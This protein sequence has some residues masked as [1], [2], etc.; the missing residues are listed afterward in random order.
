MGGEAEAWIRSI[1]RRTVLAE[2]RGAVGREWGRMLLEGVQR[3]QSTSSRAPPPLPAPLPAAG[4]VRGALRALRRVGDAA[5][6]AGRGGCVPQQ[7][8][9]PRARGFPPTAAAG[10]GAPL[11]AGGVESGASHCMR[12]CPCIVGRPMGARMAGCR[13]QADTGMRL[14]ARSA[15]KTVMLLSGPAS[16]LKTFTSD[17]RMRSTFRQGTPRGV[18]AD[19]QTTLGCMFVLRVSTL[20]SIGC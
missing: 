4:G 5:G 17:L 3:E 19:R 10:R 9:R 14:S 13:T 1:E 8:V 15:A 6:A 12:L 11:R 7:S 2:V 18:A 16:Y 20:C